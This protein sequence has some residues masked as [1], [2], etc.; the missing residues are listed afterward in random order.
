MNELKGYTIRI[1]D[2][3]IVLYFQL[4][5]VCSSFFGTTNSTPLIITEAHSSIIIYIHKGVNGIAVFAYA[6]ISSHQSLVSSG[7]ASR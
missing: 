2:A 1:S 7:N 3:K 4:P 5:N 6:L